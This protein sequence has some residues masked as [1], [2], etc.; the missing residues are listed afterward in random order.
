M[1]E[2]PGGT[3]IA[4]PGET[5]GAGRWFAEEGGVVRCAAE[6][7]AWKSENAE[8]LDSGR[9]AGRDSRLEDGPESKLEGGLESGPGM[10]F[11]DGRED[12]PVTIRFTGLR[13][14][15]LELDGLFASGSAGRTGSEAKSLL[16][17][18]AGSVGGSLLP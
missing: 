3:G 4:P 9:V 1:A 17:G 15:S 12:S 14:I 7:A 10:G 11:T 6:E 5:G 18:L 2:D 16:G 8:G 13:K